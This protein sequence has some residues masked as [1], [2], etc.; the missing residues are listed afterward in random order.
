MR[1]ARRAFSRHEAEKRG[2]SG[3]SDAGG[4]MGAEREATAVKTVGR[5]CSVGGGVR[6]SSLTDH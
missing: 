5:C 2:G 1:V 6:I 3:G 4:R